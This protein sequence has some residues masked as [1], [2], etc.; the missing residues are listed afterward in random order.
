ML[1][2]A[3][4]ESL[5]QQRADTAIKILMSEGEIRNTV[6]K[7]LLANKLSSSFDFVIITLAKK[8]NVI[9]HAIPNNNV[10]LVS[11]SDVVSDVAR[12]IGLDE[13]E[14]LL[15]YNLEKIVFDDPDLSITRKQEGSKAITFFS[16]YVS[17][18]KQIIDVEKVDFF[19]TMGEDRL[20]NM[21]PYL[22]LKKQN[23]RSWLLR[24][25]PYFGFTATSDFMGPLSQLNK[26]FWTPTEMEVNEYIARVVDGG[27]Y[28]A[29][30]A[31]SN[32]GNATNLR[33]VVSYYWEC[34]N[35]IDNPYRWT[36]FFEAKNN[37]YRAMHRKLSRVKY[38]KIPTG[39]FIFFPLHYIDDAQVRLKAPMFYNQYALINNIALCL[40]SDY[41]LVVKPHPHFDG[42]YDERELNGLS[43][44]PK[45]CLIHPSVSSRAIIEK[46]KAIITIN[47]TVGYESLLLRKPVYCLGTPF[48]ANFGGVRRINMTSLGLDLDL[49]D[50]ALHAMEE[51]I[52]SQLTSNLQGLLGGSIRGGRLGGDYLS[53]EN[54]SLLKELID[55]LVVAE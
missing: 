37:L 22:L 25:T 27:A 13:M 6:A 19:L 18:M 43:K 29:P 55:K 40:P 36:R 15:E 4:E 21:V 24:S 5:G 34:I 32:K 28:G 17:A 41:S 1:H 14:S 20:Y 26:P 30:Y 42:G 10:K 54:V 3:S 47:S 11:I 12:P 33:E 53:D 35:E 52:A 51:E 16:E 39:N 2:N 48:Y 31:M 44:N 49:T 45:V 7:V 9:K 23:K 8:E 50:E 46:S 38:S